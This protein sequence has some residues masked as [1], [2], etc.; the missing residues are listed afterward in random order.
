MLHFTQNRDLKV[1]E[2]EKT[3]NFFSFE[4]TIK[5]KS[6]ENIVFVISAFK[7][8]FYYL[9]LSF[10]YYKSFFFL[11]NTYIT[12]PELPNKILN[13]KYFRPAG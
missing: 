4:E 10:Y 1:K 3:C 2:K 5:C 11:L 7:C 13:I 12:N 9:T 8:I 6:H